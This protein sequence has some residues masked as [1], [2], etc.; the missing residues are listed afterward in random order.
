MV[1]GGW[2]NLFA[3]LECQL[4]YPGTVRPGHFQWGAAEFPYDPPA[5]LAVKLESAAAT[6]SIFTYDQV[7]TWPPRRCLL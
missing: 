5:S 4:E 3:H 6:A 2:T 1:G 7:D